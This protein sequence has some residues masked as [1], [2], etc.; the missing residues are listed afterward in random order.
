[1]SIDNESSVEVAVNKDLQVIDIIPYDKQG[2]AVLENIV[3][4]KNKDLGVVS[5]KIMNE[6]ETQG[7]IDQDEI[8]VGTVYKGERN[9]KADSNLQKEI[10]QL[11]EHGT[12]D[13]KTVTVYQATAEERSKAKAQGIT[14]G[15]LKQSSQPKKA[16]DSA[17]ENNTKVEQKKDNKEYQTELPPGQIKKEQL[18]VPAEPSV[19]QGQIGVPQ[20]DQGDEKKQ[21]IEN[22]T[23][24]QIPDKQDNFSKNGKQQENQTDKPNKKIDKNK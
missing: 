11:K 17:I 6:M 10:A 4:W 15:E 2:E 3:D 19:D 7:F 22:K 9:K 13:D 5:K 23:H 1:M 16:D 21:P 24:K 18:S 20:Q 12:I 14:A 8:V